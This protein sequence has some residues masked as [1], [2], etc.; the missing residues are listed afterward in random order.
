MMMNFGAKSIKN[1]I[2]VSQKWH[3]RLI[4][5]LS[6][7]FRLLL[8]IP[9]HLL[10]QILW[11]CLC[12]ASKWDFYLYEFKDTPVDQSDKAFYHEALFLVH[13]LSV[14]HVD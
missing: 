1:K 2:S 11:N 7:L 4:I 10:Y 12:D 14:S 9:L 13:G 3:D 5:E 6:C 8:W